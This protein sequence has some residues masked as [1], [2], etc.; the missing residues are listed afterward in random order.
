MHYVGM[1]RSN[2]FRVKDFEA[3]EAWVE[4]IPELVARRTVNEE[5]PGTEV[6]LFVEDCDC[7]V[8]PRRRWDETEDGK[9]GEFDVFAELA[10]HLVP[11]SV[12]VGLEIVVE[13]NHYLGGSATAV[14]A[15]GQQI[16]LRLAE[17]FTLAEQK[18]GEHATVNAF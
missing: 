18:F 1:A 12:A 6:V 7:G 15:S 4:T 16:N 17:I 13:G 3:F 5:G 8:W 10:E 14:D 9:E 2:A 11:G